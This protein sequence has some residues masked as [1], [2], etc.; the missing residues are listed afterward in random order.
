MMTSLILPVLLHAPTGFSRKILC[1][2]NHDHAS[3]LTDDWLILRCLTLYKA[4]NFGH[5][6]IESSCRQQIKRC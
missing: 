5:D 3:F 2:R 6:Q 4:T 1:Q